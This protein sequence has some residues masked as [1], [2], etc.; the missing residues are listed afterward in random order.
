MIK[1]LQNRF[2]RAMA[3]LGNRWIVPVIILAVIRRIFDF[4]YWYVVGG[5]QGIFLSMARAIAE[6]R[7][8]Y[9]TAHPLTALDSGFTSFAPSGHPLLIAFFSIFFQ[10][11]VLS[12]A[13]LSFLCGIGAL[14]LLVKL[15]EKIWGRGIAFMTGCLAAIH[16]I[17]SEFSALHYREMTFAFFL[18]AMLYVLFK[19]IKKPSPRNML[20]TG[21]LGGFVAIIRPDGFLYFWIIPIYLILTMKS[22]KIKLF[23]LVGG[24]LILIL[25]F[26]V[27]EKLQPQE[28]ILPFTNAAFNMEYGSRN[29]LTRRMWILGPDDKMQAYTRLKDTGTLEYIFSNL[30]D[31]PSRY[32]R[33][34]LGR[35]PANRYYRVFPGLFVIFIIGGLFLIPG[36]AR[37]RSFAVFLLFVSVFPFIYAPLSH[38]EARYLVAPLHLY[39][40]PASFLIILASTGLLHVLK[41]NKARYLWIVVVILLIGI[42]LLFFRGHKLYHASRASSLEMF[43]RVKVVSRY[44]KNHSEPAD[45]VSSFYSGIGFFSQ[46]TQRIFPDMKFAG[47]ISWLKR[48]NIDYAALDKNFVIQNRPEM[49][50]LAFPEQCKKDLELVLSDPVKS[51]FLYRMR[52][53]TNIP[54]RNTIQESVKNYAE[55]MKTTGP[56]FLRN[57]AQGRYYIMQKQPEKAVR[58]FRKIKWFHNFEIYLISRRELYFLLRNMGKPEQAKG[59]ARILDI[60]DDS[61]P[62]RIMLYTDQYEQNKQ[63]KKAEADYREAI[64]TKDTPYLRFRFG[65]LLEKQKQYRAALKQFR[66]AD[67]MKPHPEHLLGIIRCLEQLHLYDDIKKACTKGIE[68][69][70]HRKEF[71]TYLNSIPGGKSDN[72]VTHNSRIIL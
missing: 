15:T 64:S 8:Y 36:A 19:V 16:P 1:R 42:H 37:N 3:P 14:I 71:K 72:S 53:N 39:L 9:T 7:L 35:G 24:Y 47:Y 10:N 55:Q 58:E 45:Q 2:E 6:G 21:L 70:P 5:D 27:H 43:Y 51:I 69:Y 33:V 44:L 29:D 13:V 20:F 12:S 40:I 63:W 52:E 17:L 11:I 23:Y 62:F 66:K 54:P 68:R 61:F 57:L 34:Y 49:T 22:G 30:K 25:P 32:L 26:F 60:F 48:N 67:R 56:A 18:L 4:R 46:R 41:L 65:Q 31:F 38:L 59:A 50:P 28:R